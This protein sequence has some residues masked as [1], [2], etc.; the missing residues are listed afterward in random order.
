MVRRYMDD[1]GPEDMVTPELKLIQNVGGEIAKGQ[2]AKPGDFYISMTDEVIPGDIGLDIVIVDIPKNRTYWGRSEIDVEPPECASLDARSMRSI[3]NDDCSKC[4]K[5][6]EM[7]GLEKDPTERRK[8]CS[9]GYSILAIR[10]D[11][12][13][14]PILFRAHGISAKPTRELNSALKLNRQ[15][16]GACEKVLI[17]MTSAKQKTASGEA[18]AVAFKLKALI[19][20]EKSKEFLIET[21]QILGC[22]PVLL[23]EAASVETVAQIEAKPE[24]LPVKT[25][26]KPSEPVRL[27]KKTPELPVTD[28]NF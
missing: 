9:P 6:V 27:P 20:D 13:R 4:D 17:H 26:E 24:K 12:S 11:E 7:P 10:A 25:A 22:A 23:A 16:K 15:I 19:S 1:Y 14:M 21:E 2:G 18:F 3:F 5:R 28:L 8:K